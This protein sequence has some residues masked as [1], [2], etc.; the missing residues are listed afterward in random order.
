MLCEEFADVR[1]LWDM[2]AVKHWGTKPASEKQ[3]A[4]I[5]KRCKGF[6]TGELN[7]MQASMI[8]NRV[9][10]GEKRRAG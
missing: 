2:N 10:S 9:M 5:R 8:L 4:I 6:E 7:T 3:L 1:A